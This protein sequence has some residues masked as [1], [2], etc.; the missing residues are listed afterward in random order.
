MRIFKSTNIEAS[1][2]DV[3]EP[4]VD[5][6]LDLIENKKIVFKNDVAYWS[7]G[8]RVLPKEYR[9]CIEQ[10]QYAHWINEW[11]CE[12]AEKFGDRAYYDYDGDTEVKASNMRISKSNKTSVK[13]TTGLVGKMV[14]VKPY[15]K[16]KDKDWF[17]DDMKKYCGNTYEVQSDVDDDFVYLYDDGKGF[18]FH[19]DGLTVVGVNACEDIKAS[20]CLE[21]RQRTAVDGK[22][23]WVVYDTCNKKYSTLTCF[24]KY[25]TKKDCQYAINKYNETNVEASKN[26]SANDKALQH[27]K[28]AIDILGKSGNK[29]AVTKDSIANL[30]TVMF[31]IKAST[32]TAASKCKYSKKECIDAIQ[33][34]YGKNKK[35]AEE[36]YKSADAK[37]LEALVDGFKGNAKK[38]FLDD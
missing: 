1:T 22:T 14:K 6:V 13:A 21:P 4:T 8:K 7:R 3:L 5:N 31:D 33:D 12:Q 26:V 30:A 9:A 25:A 16:L 37:T 11:S 32:V 10:T 24:G 15:T 23:W 38:A 18:Q 35:E 2:T 27:I 19:K 36:Y 20:S 28:A 29:D 17:V 34:Q